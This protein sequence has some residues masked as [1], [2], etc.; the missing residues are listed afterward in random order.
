MKFEVIDFHTHPFPCSVNNICSHKDVIDMDKDH[1]LNL[2]DKLS[3]TKFC[4]SVISTYHPK[5][6]Q[7]NESEWTRIQQQNQLALDLQK[8]YKGRYIPGFH[9]H[10]DFVE[11][12]FK[13]IDKMK[14][15]GVNLVGELVPYMHNYSMDN[16]GKLDEILDYAEKQ[17]MIVSFHTM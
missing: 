2:M 11:E 9:I 12:S 7:E 6:Y 10:P 17:D 3:I 16:G 8:Y 1:I 4:G 15:L 13:E 14:G 5:T